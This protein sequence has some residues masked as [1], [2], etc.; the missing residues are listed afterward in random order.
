MILARNFEIGTS[1]ELKIVEDPVKRSTAIT[2]SDL[3][4]KQKQWK[5]VV[6]CFSV[7]AALLCDLPTQRQASAIN[8]SVVYSTDTFGDESPSWDPNGAILTAHFNAA[9]DIWEELIPSPGNYEFD[10]QWDDD[11]SGLGLTTDL[12]PIDTW[13]EINPNQ[14]WWIDTTPADNVEFNLTGAQT[15]FNQLS[16]ANQSTI[17][18]GT[19][20]PGTL[21]VGF[22]GTGLAAFGNAPGQPGVNANSGFDLLSTVVHEIGHVLGIGADLLGEPGEFNIFPQHVGGLSDVLVLEDDDS[23]HLGGDGAVPFLMCQGWRSSVPH[24]N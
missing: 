17:F 8:I 18:P 14:P 9:V 7:I 6:I 21:E 2:V 11:I 20:P 10:F 4:R 23:G 22:R 15:L 13:I 16:A 24:R 1:R 5:N 12:Q 19:T 3:L